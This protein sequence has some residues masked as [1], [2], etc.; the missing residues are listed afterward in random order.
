MAGF[1]PASAFNPYFFGFPGAGMMPMFSMG[2]SAA[3]F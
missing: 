3:S 2:G 1:D